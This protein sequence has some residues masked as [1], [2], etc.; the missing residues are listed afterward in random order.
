MPRHPGVIFTEIEALHVLTGVEAM[1]VAAG[2]VGGAEGAVWLQ[3][4]QAVQDGS[5]VFGFAVGRYHP[6]NTMSAK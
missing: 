2:G 4:H 6:Q 5:S 1:H 3:I